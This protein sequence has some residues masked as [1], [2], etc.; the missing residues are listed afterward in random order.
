M[1]VITANRKSFKF[2]N[3]FDYK[4]ISPNYAGVDEMFIDGC[5]VFT[6]EGQLLDWPSEWLSDSMESNRRNH[7][8][9]KEYARVIVSFLEFLIKREHD[10]KRP[11][12]R[13][14][15]AIQ[16]LL[17]EVNNKVVL[18]YLNDYCV[19]LDNGV[20]SYRDTVLKQFYEEYICSYFYG[21]NSEIPLLDEAFNPFRDFS[22]DGQTKKLFNAASKVNDEGGGLG[23]SLDNLMDFMVVAKNER[24]RCL[25]QFMYDSGL[26]VGEIP[27]V[28]R[29]DI[30]EALIRYSSYEVIDIEDHGYSESNYKTLAVKGVKPR[31]REKYKTR[32]T[33]VS[34]ITLKRLKRYFEQKR[35][36]Y[37]KHIRGT[38]IEQ[39]KAFLNAYGEPISAQSISRLITERFKEGKKI[40][41]FRHRVEPITPHKFRHGFS[42]ACLA[43]LDVKEDS[44]DRM[45]ALSKWL[46]HNHVE[47]TQKHYQSI[48]MDLQH[49]LESGELLN[50]CDLMLEVYSKTKPSEIDNYRKLKLG[51]TK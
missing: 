41:L 13:N 10:F 22:K 30:N 44:H 50:R 2:T 1:F 38:P 33:Y 4:E 5:F 51:T 25:F 8:T 37:M 27:S 11:K 43:S 14:A 23:I 17:L 45:V 15:K 16:N 7:N 35:G 34:T 9:A 32:Y 21:K 29:S 39:Q 31:N 3:E 24:E 40:G 36:F 12:P 47:T 26:R 19:S 18:K 28:L 20:K 42:V 48:A 46:G 49:N 6:K